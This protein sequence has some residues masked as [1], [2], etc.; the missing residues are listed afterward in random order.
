MTLRESD[1]F[2]SCR[3][4]VGVPTA[5]HMK[6]IARRQFVRIILAALLIITTLV[7]AQPRHEA[8]AQESVD[9]LAGQFNNPPDD[10]RIMMRW[11]WF[12]PSVTI[13]RI[14][15]EMLLM[16]EGGIGGFEIQPVYPVAL[17]DGKIRTIPYLSDEFLDI[18]R[19]T[20]RRAAE[21]GL[22]VDL[23]IG[24]GWPY[25]GPTVPVTQA[26]GRL[27]VEKTR[28]VSRRVPLP[29]ISEGESLLAVFLRRANGS[30]TI[31]SFNRI[32]TIREGAALLPEV[33]QK[34]D[35]VFFFISSRTGMMV[36]R[37]AIGAEGFVLDHYDRGAIDDYLKNVG[38]RLM[39]SFD[40]QSPY[41]IFCDSL[42]VF[43]SDW[44]GDYLAEFE[45]RRGYDLKPLLPALAA[46]IGPDTESIRHDWAMTLTEI[47]NDRFLAPM[48]DWSRANKTRF[49]MQGYGIP[50]MTLSGNA[51]L[52]LPEGEGSQW[53]VV[54]AS[55]WAA[56]ASH[57]YDKPVTS[58]ETWTW[59]HSPSFRATPLDVKAEADLHFLQGINQLI[60]HGWPYTADGAD[61][62][63]WRFYAAGV[64]NEKNPWWPVMPDLSKYLQRVSFMLRQGKPA[65][66]I[67]LYL[68]TS[69]AWASYSNGHVGYLI[70]RLRDR[71]GSECMPAILGAGFNLDFFDD[72]AL[73]R[74]GRI[75]GNDMAMGVNRYKAVILPNVERIPLATLQRL[76]AFVDQGGVVIATR[77]IPD[78]A[79]G[80]KAS[81]DERSRIRQISARLFER[82]NAKAHLVHDEKGALGAKLASLVRPDVAFSQPGTDIGF[83]H[84]STESAEIY[85]IANTTNSTR[86]FNAEF[87]VKGMNAEIWDPLSG[88]VSPAPA[89]QKGVS[90]TVL[91]FEIEPYG[92][93]L[94]VFS[95]RTLPAVTAR[96]ATEL[97]AEIDLSSD[98]R[99]D[100][101]GSK[102]TLPQLKSWTD[103]DE[104]RYF[105]GT[106]VYEKTIHVPAEWLQKSFEV[107][108]DFGSGKVLVEQELRNG[109]RSWLDAPVR[110]AAVI[111]VNGKR[112]GSLWC[113]PYS[114]DI[115][116]LL[117]AGDNTLR[118]EVGNTA[119]NHLA[120]R[121][122]PDYRLLNLRYGERFKPQDMDNLEPLPSGLLGPIRLL[123]R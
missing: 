11:W 64:F 3:P 107:R 86:S 1:I 56:S 103:D 78:L 85:F 116:R 111:S 105:S 53:K 43:N 38:D 54:R 100:I 55:R 39:R 23:T 72:E 51:Y 28:P 7:S 113:P 19:Y 36:K 37:P 31:E 96:A 10:A 29:D 45:K 22:R 123:V 68:P 65:N 106:A 99:L 80:F 84:R 6:I 50:P 14:E 59:L 17:D 97:R 71:V 15:R 92:S 87:R 25:G 108:L 82:A 34:G 26:A 81:A 114:I 66:D 94:V 24:S 60:G 42:E 8:S 112:A 57:L 18:L 101:N 16:K 47:F 70:E 32:A 40:Y 30:Q 75:E 58:S 88:S 95:K 44:T 33:P 104:H 121:R 76:E 2:H 89:T 62:P 21:L 46:D 93:R 74:L 63:G 9:K 118:I 98:W 119:I 61:Y 77:R 41:A 5:T 48:R 20:N 52:D 73:N 67:A 12:G 49:R 110:D 122:L 90:G 27:R 83:I 35:E 115:T 120:G 69:D 117:K 109:M 13:E 4:E 102:K 79:P 91:A